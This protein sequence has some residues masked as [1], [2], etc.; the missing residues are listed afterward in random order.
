MS[1]GAFQKASRSARAADPTLMPC[2]RCGK[3]LDSP[4]RLVD[5]LALRYGLVLAISALL[6]A[7]A[8][9]FRERLNL[10]PET[11]PK[12]KPPIEVTL[13]P[14]A[15]PVAPA[16]AEPAG[17]SQNPEPVK[18]AVKPAEA[19][20]KAVAKPPK[21]S[22]PSVSKPS[23]PPKPERPAVA[24]PPVLEPRIEPIHPPEP[25]PKPVRRARLPDEPDPSMPRESQPV[26]P[27]PKPRRPTRRE[28]ED[29]PNLPPVVRPF[30]PQPVPPP[31]KAVPKPS[32]LPRPEDAD[33][34]PQTHR[35]PPVHAPT[36]PRD[37]ARSTEPPSPAR[38]GRGATNATQPENTSRGSGAPGNTRPETAASGK[39]GGGFEGARANAAYLHNPKPEY[40]PLARRRQWEGRVILKVRVLAAGTVAAISVETSSGHEILDEAALEAVR[41]WRFVPAKRGGQAVDSVVNVPIN[42]NLLD[43]Q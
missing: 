31:P 30:E 20:P 36:A 5:S 35:R 28:I 23:A 1:L 13:A 9:L 27:T 32:P 42:F 34:N 11:L 6:H 17:A 38:G 25:R 41:R 14:L 19:P 26:P 33:E 24:K 22:A 29:D 18:P 37:S 8:W 12:P 15:K 2:W 43:S 16:P 10:Y 40:P 39:P 3:A 7:G 21:S 4:R